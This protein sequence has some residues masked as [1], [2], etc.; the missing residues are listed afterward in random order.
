MEVADGRGLVIRWVEFVADM[1][2]H[3]GQDAGFFPVQRVA[4]YFFNHSRK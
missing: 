2:T 1:H 3:F 4:S